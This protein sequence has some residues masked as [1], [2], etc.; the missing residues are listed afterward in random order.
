MERETI[1]SNSVRDANPDRVCQICIST[2]CGSPT[3]PRRARIVCFR[4]FLFKVDIEAPDYSNIS[5]N[6]QCWISPVNSR[7]NLM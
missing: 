3:L 1:Q 5:K 2:L 6:N 7:L 4:N